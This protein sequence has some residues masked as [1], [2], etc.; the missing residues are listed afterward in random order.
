[1]TVTRSILLATAALAVVGLAACDNGPSAVA[2][3]QAAATQMADAAPTADDGRALDRRETR[4]DARD[5]PVPLVDGKPMW[6]AS[7][8]YS[9]E[10]N[11]RRAFARNGEAFGAGSLEA[12]VDKAH[13]FVQRPPR[14]AETLTRAN[15][16]VLIYDPR[17]NVFAVRS[18]DGAPRTMFKPDDGAAYWA[19]QKTREARRATARSTREDDAA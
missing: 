13:A 4:D 16:D 6:S 11:A 17:S 1:M 12:F 14:G 3:P 19:E 9:A 10:E 5:A 18:K 2:P 8:R 7:R 15:G